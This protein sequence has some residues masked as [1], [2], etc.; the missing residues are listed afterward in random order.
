MWVLKFTFIV[1]GVLYE[2]LHYSVTSMY[3]ALSKRI[4][5]YYR[6]NKGQA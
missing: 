3:N 5:T 4:S 2:L 1:V 6:T